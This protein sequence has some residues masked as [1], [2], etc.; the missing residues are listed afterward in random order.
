M[1]ANCSCTEPVNQ[2]H[3]KCAREGLLC[4]Q[5]HNPSSSLLTHLRVEVVSIHVFSH[6]A[7]AIRPGGREDRL[8]HPIC[9]KK[10]A[11]P[12]CIK[13]CFV[14]WNLQPST[15]YLH[16]YTR[17]LGLCEFLGAP[18]RGLPEQSRATR[19]QHSFSSCECNLPKQPGHGFC[20]PRT[21]SS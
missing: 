14:T 4:N 7:N 12:V 8:E 21:R 6:P 5:A 19:L 15:V 2:S 1:Q 13:H 11:N 18:R 9:I 16:R 3:L 17:L 10:Y 20:A